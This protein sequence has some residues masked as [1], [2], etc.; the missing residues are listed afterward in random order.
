MLGNIRAQMLAKRSYSS[1]HAPQ[2][3]LFMEVRPK[4][5]DHPI[6][7]MKGIEDIE[8]THRKPENIKEHL[9]RF[10]I[11]ILRGSFDILSRYSEVKMSESKW[12]TRCIFLEAVAGVP[13]MVGGMTR[14][15][16]S[17]RTMRPDH[18]I[19]HHLLEEAENERTHLFMFIQ[20][21]EP[22]F[23]M[24]LGVVLTQGVFWNFYFLCYLVSPRF[25][26]SLVGYLEEEAVH[27]YSMLLKQL[28]EG[29]LEKWTNTR[30]PEIAKEYY[31]LS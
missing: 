7:S 10:A 4:R 29:K 20:L 2:H 30:C 9:A 18:G 14:H 28:D 26:H 24:R 6:Y 25:C 13:G 16:K 22:S 21:K 11:R 1:F 15:L 19:I 23:L 5:L 12:L 3:K 17:L 27:T 31:E 8:E